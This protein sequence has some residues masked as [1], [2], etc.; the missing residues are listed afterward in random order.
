MSKSQPLVIDSIQEDNVLKIL[1]RPSLRSSINLGWNNI[2]VQQHQQPAWEMPEYC[3]IQHMILIHGASQ[4]ALTERWFDGQKRR[5]YLGRGNNVVIVP[6]AISHRASW[7]EENPFSLMFLEPDYLNQVAFEA[8]KTG[9][10][11]LLPQGAMDDPFI[12]QI[13][14]ALTAELEHEQIHSRLFIES[15]TTALAIHILRNY[16][17][18]QQPIRDYTGGLSQPK[19]EQAIGF[20][21]ESL[22]AEDLTVAAI[23]AQVEMSQYYFTRLF[24]ESMGVSPYQYIVRLRVE[25]AASLLRT[26]SLSIAAIAAQTGFS[27]Q[28]QLTIQFRK[29]MDTAPRDYRKQL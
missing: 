9:R 26:T 4:P 15:V 18:L 27:N 19:L 2:Y 1:P 28:N 12:E 3:Y 8:I 11:E 7:G 5:E 21:R 20:I 17:N 22:A 6:A 29:I 13:G 25:K 16:A 10:A 23:A 24:K 14:Q